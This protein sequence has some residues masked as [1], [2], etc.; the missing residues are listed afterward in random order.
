MASM[1]TLKFGDQTERIPL[2]EGSIHI[3][4]VKDAFALR[5]ARIDGALAP[6]DR[7][8]FTYA[9]LTLGTSSVSVALQ[10][11]LLPRQV[12]HNPRASQ[13]HDSYIAVLLWA[14]VL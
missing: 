10:L 11:E 14:W 13:V 7:Q 8:G 3:P 1:V 5:F 9:K 12:H 2:I 6:V 4:T